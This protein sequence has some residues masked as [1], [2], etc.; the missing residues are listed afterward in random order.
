MA[1]GRTL[2]GSFKPN[3]AVEIVPLERPSW[4]LPQVAESRVAELESSL[5]SARRESGLLGAVATNAVERRDMLVAELRVATAALEAAQV[6]PQHTRARAR[7]QS[8][9][10]RSVTHLRPNGPQHAPLSH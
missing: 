6:R 4:P 7:R 1:E 9:P 10:A 8:A 2:P 3:L 5:E